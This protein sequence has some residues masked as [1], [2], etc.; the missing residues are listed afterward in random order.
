MEKRENVENP[1]EKDNAN[2]HANAEKGEVIK[3]GNE[4]GNEFITKPTRNGS[5][6]ETEQH[7]S[8][9]HMSGGR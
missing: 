7:E 3:V 2:G 9:Y 8:V 5:E 4:K 6:K 1:A